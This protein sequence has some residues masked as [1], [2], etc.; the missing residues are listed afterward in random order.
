MTLS[1]WLEEEKQKR[2]K[3]DPGRG[4]QDW[5]ASKL[6][7]D[8]GLVSKWVRRVSTPERYGTKIVRLS[9]GNVTLPELM[10]VP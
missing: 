4:T 3:R 5:L 7:V 2:T 9:G 10:R 1:E 8:Q 6:D